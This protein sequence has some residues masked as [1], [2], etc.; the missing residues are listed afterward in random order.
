MPKCQYPECKE[1]A[2]NGN[3]CILHDAIVN[4]I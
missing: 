4:D 1:N 3:Y 2:I